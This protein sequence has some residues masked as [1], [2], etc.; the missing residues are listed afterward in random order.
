MGKDMANRTQKLTQENDPYVLPSDNKQLQSFIEKYKVDMTE[1]V[2]SSIEFAVKH[3]LPIIEVFQFKDSKFVVTVAPKEFDTNL[4]N[5]YKFYLQAEHYE[6]CK[7]V[8]KLRQ[9]LGKTL[10]EKTKKPS[11]GTQ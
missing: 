5:I 8:V 9:K 7:R 3:N 6:L 1:Q 2:V 4:E 10:N 11:T